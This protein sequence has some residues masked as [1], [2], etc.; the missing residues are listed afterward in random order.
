VTGAVRSLL[1]PKVH[2]RVHKSPLPDFILSQMSPA[3]T[4]TYFSKI[5]FNVIFPSTPRSSKWYF[6]CSGPMLSLIEIHAPCVYRR[7]VRRG[8][9]VQPAYRRSVMQLHDLQINK[10]TL[11]SAS[12]AAPAYRCA[13]VHSDVIRRK[14]A[15][16][17]MTWLNIKCLLFVPIVLFTFS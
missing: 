6:L 5:H 12:C 1:N 3:H 9:G 2:Y 14:N 16:F 11:Q 13:A 7:V 10:W 8:R 17:V 4:L 15:I